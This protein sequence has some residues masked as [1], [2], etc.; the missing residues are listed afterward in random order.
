MVVNPNRT[1][2]STFKDTFVNIFEKVLKQLTAPSDLHVD[3]TVE[4]L[5]EG[6]TMWYNE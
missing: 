6:K 1:L 2:A 4:F 5:E 3:V